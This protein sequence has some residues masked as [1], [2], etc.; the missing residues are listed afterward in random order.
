VP[1][2][3]EARRLR[4]EPFVQAVREDPDLTILFV[5]DGSTDETPTVLRGICEQAPERLGHI[6]LERNYGKAEAV[7]RGLVRAMGQDVAIVGFWDADLAAPLSELPGLAAALKSPGIEIALASRVRLLGR[8]IERRAVRH[9]LGRLFATAASLVLRLPVYDTQC[10]A[11]LFARTEA[12]ARVLERPFLA[13]WIF[14]VE[15]LARLAVE[16]GG[17]AALLHKVVE[18][19]LSRWRDVPGSKLSAWSAIRVGVEFLRVAWWIHRHR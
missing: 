17:P 2:Y 4:A 13:R 9:Y 12:L 1:C 7:R 16:S 14:D 10:G 8:S 5:D 18:V 19:P 15:I 6:T 11:K 3:N